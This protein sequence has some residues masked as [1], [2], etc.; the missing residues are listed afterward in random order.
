L[1]FDKIELP[2]LLITGTNMDKFQRFF[3]GNLKNH[4]FDFS[5]KANRSQFWYFVLF[6]FIFSI[7]ATLSDVY[8]I[9]PAL[10]MNMEEAT[11]GGFLQVIFAVVMFIPL[12]A[13]KIRRLHDI[14]KSGWFILLNFIPVVGTFILIYFYVQKSE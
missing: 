11:K 4:F 7:V 2:S 10:G 5:G 13:I 8:L 9:N 12:L 6:V 1:A 3:I 14:G